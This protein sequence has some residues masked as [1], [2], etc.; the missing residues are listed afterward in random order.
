[1]KAIE[2]LIRSRVNMDSDVLEDASVP[3]DELVAA[4]RVGS[5]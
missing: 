5:G 3:I 2:R 4:A 1:M